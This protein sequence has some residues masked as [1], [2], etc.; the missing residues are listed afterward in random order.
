MPSRRNPKYTLVSLSLVSALAGVALEPR[1]AVAQSGPPPIPQEA[2]AACDSKAA[3][4]ACSVRFAGQDL[5]GTCT[6]EPS[7]SRLVCLPNDR[8]PPPR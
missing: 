8:P 7:G 1:S 4:D 2:Y 3:G 5:K 6:T